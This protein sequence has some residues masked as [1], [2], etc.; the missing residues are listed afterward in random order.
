MPKA[1]IHAV[2]LKFEELG[3]GLKIRGVLA[4]PIANANIAT[5]TGVQVFQKGCSHSLAKLLI[6]HDSW[7]AG[8][9]FLNQMLLEPVLRLAAHQSPIHRTQLF[10]CEVPG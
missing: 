4:G 10:L 8:W 9:A 3:G 5:Q 2:F 6:Q 1:N 7:A